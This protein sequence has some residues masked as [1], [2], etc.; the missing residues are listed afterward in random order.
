MNYP[1]EP[2]DVEAVRGVK[3]MTERL[4]Y[5]KREWQ[6]A[7]PTVCSKSSVAFSESWQ[8]TEGLP[9]ELRWAK[10]FADRLEAAQP[11]IRQGELII[12]SLT[13]HIKGVDVIAAYRP[14]QILRM[15]KDNKFE[16]RLR[17][18]ELAEI[19]GED[20]DRL[21][22]DATFWASR[23]APDYINRA[24]VEK[25]GEDHLELLA[26]RS[27]VFEDYFAMADLSRGIFNQGFS[28]S[29]AGM[30]AP[31]SYVLDTGLRAI[32]DRAKAEMANM[33]SEGFDLTSSDSASSH[34]Y[35]LLESIVIS[36]QAII[37]WANRHA[38]LA[39]RLA[40]CETNL[41]RKKELLKIADHCERVPASPPRTFWEAVQSLRFIHLAIKKEQPD[42]PSVILGRM[43]QMLYPYYKRDLEEGRI[44][45]QE[46]AELLGCLWL[47]TRE[48]EILET[49][50][51]E[52]RIAPGTLLQNVTIGGRDAEGRD[53]TN[54]LSWLILQVMSQM[55]LS[56]PAVYV[57]CHKGMSDEFLRFGLECSRDFGGGNP[58]FLNDELGTD[59]WLARGIDRTDAVDWEATGCLAIRLT[60]CDPPFSMHL[61]QAKILEIALHNGA[62][63]RTGMQLGP[64]TGDVAT[65][66]S[67]EQVYDAFFTQMDY[68]AGAM[69]E[70]LAVRL[71]ADL[72]NSPVSGLSSA[73]IEGSMSKGLAPI[74]GGNKY[75]VCNTL[76]IAD[77]GITDVTDS[78]AAIK[79]LVFDTKRLSMAELLGALDANWQGEEGIHR[80]CLAAP[81]YG[82]DDAYVDDILE[83]VSS[84]TREILQ[85][86]PCPV[87][88]QKPFLFRGAAAGHV[89]HGLVV[90]ALPNGRQAGMPINDAGTSAM[91]GMDVNGP[92]ALINSATKMDY[93]DF[94]G[95]AHNMK[96]SKQLMNN[97]K[98][99]EKIAALLKVYFQRGGW[100][101]QFNIHNAE[102]LIEAKQHPDRR[103][104]LIVRV[105]GYSAYFVDLAPVLQDEIIHRTLHE[106]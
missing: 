1:C 56:E 42:R 40:E 91:P 81:K 64:L 71:P 10:S 28:G 63:P 50:T 24:I 87:T 103:R 22:K 11:V 13:E 29:W 20:L 12:G 7:Q 90:G 53:V 74:E 30:P 5:R 46:A 88:G 23:V 9:L 97:A 95:V 67:I 92:T 36:C 96:F 86:R 43:D 8:K 82:N 61:N 6:Q 47:K 79:Y 19:S 48:M 102:D 106:V 60:S 15:A 34:K 21:E 25:L 65:L 3:V 27:M 57:R 73:L 32:I 31:N 89:I 2:V 18:T 26:D 69:R 38:A 101:I 105:G 100:H 14:R 66:T 51:K 68:F 41:V 83:Y 49:V 80:M 55:K 104:D 44:T 58:A 35:L 72:A 39:G 93:S 84:R 45:R 52:F 75:D 78:L 4:Q 59:T 99:L 37:D 33:Q 77:R 98:N 94:M 76:W 17:D 62:D 85:S 54:E 70:D 16:S